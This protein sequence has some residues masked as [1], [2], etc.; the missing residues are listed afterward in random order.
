MV[1]ATGVPGENHS[2]DTMNS[3]QF[4]NKKFYRVHLPI[5]GIPKLTVAVV[6]MYYICLVNYGMTT[7]T[8][9]S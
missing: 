5:D 9:V 7:F 1:M 6:N 8:T 2:L 4:Y 3:D